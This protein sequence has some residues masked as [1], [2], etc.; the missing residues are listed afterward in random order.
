MKKKSSLPERLFAKGKRQQYIYRQIFF[1]LLFFICG[2][3]IAVSSNDIKPLVFIHELGHFLAAR[4]LGAE[5]A[6]YGVYTS[7]DVSSTVIQDHDLA[8]IFLAGYRAELAIWYVLIVISLIINVYRIRWSKPGVLYPLAFLPGYATE[9][10]RLIQEAS[11]LKR[12]SLLLDI[13]MES[14]VRLF[15]V[16]ESL[17]LIAIYVVYVIVLL[18]VRRQV[19]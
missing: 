13:D 18:H 4:M 5:A 1:S 3:A 7:I 6:I 14:V 15:I 2:I 11:D 17:V 8:R 10:F 19:R 9:T 12:A 16:R